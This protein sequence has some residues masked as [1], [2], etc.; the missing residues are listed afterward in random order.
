[1][2]QSDLYREIARITGETV[3]EIRQMG[4]G[5]VVVPTCPEPTFQVGQRRAPHYARQNQAR[6]RKLPA[7]ATP[8]IAQC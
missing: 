3:T 7:M 5:L 4:F 6:C 8:S 1:M 2:S